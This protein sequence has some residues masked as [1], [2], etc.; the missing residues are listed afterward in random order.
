M[1]IHAKIASTICASVML[2]LCSHANAAEVTV[3][4]VAELTGLN[5]DIGIA[6]ARGVEVGVEYVNANSDMG[7]NKIRLLIEDDGTDKG[8]A[9]TLLNKFALQDNADLIIGT[10]SSVLGASIA[11]RAEEL[12]VPMLTIAYS[13]VVTKGHDWVF[14]ATDTIPNMFQTLA[15]YTADVIKPGSCVRVWAK[16]NQGFVVVAKVWADGVTAKGVKI[17][18]EIQILGSDTDFTAAATK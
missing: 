13:D 2:A 6:N 7:G 1:K 18:D 9:L 5:A 17:L 16:D 15:D 8:Q 11:P 4:M 12:K 14:K 10:T 3:G